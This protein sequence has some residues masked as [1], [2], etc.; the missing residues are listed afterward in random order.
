M[1]GVRKDKPAAVSSK[2]VAHASQVQHSDPFN[3]HRRPDLMPALRQR[4]TALNMR[5]ACE[6]LAAR[7]RRYTLVVVPSK[8]YRL[9]VPNRRQVSYDHRPACNK[10]RSQSA[11]SP[12]NRRCHNTKND[13]L[14]SPMQG[15]PSTQEATPFMV[16]RP[17]IP[18]QGF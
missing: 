8:L 1:E 15:A 3:Q 18:P 16:S 10:S 6:S 17:L 7:Q 4:I 13:C 12:C 5:N 2:A 11:T 14:S 9:P